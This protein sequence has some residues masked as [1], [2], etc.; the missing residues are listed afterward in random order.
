MD[1]SLMP[2]SLAPKRDVPTEMADRLI[3]ALDFT[4]PFQAREL[5]ERLDG[6]VSFFK[7][8]MAL[9]VADGT[10]TVIN[11]LLLKKKNIFLDYKM[12]DIPETVSRGVGQAL[13]RGIKF[14]T[15]HGDREI[16]QAAVSAKGDS[17]F[18]KIFAITVLTS[19]DDSDL[20][21]M[22]YAIGVSDLIRLRVRT[23]LECGVDGIIASADDA[24][25][26]I[27]QHF[28]RP[29]LLIATPGIRPQGVSTDDHK[30]FATPSEAIRRGADYLVVGRPII[31][32]EDPAAAALAI[33]EEMKLGERLRA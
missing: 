4:N 13:D 27:R 24:P 8:G 17:D 22:G 33:I 11:R 32:H 10:E 20:T 6:I 12:F 31:E 9:F 30:R 28:N 29:G 3:V 1:G 15:V 25:D 23:A 19:L 21:D 5:A 18:L 14:V 7:I 2:P 26:E 16:M